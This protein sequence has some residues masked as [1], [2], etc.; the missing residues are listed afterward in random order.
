MINTTPEFNKLTSEH[1]A[2]RLAQTNLAS[3]NDIVNFVKKTDFG[4][5]LKNLNK[6]VTSNKN[7]LNEVSKQVKAIST[8][9]LT[10]DLIN[11]F[12]I[13]NEAKCFS[14]GMFQSCLVFVPDK[15]CVKYFSGTAR[16][17]S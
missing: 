15:K 1:F 17:N 13:L 6:N 12:S 8:K 16:I 4:D 14:S 5:K 7:A 2:P 9:R 11:K 10:K 3:K